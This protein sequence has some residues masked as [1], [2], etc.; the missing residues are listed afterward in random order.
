MA[1]TAEEQAILTQLAYRDIRVPDEA[2][3][4][5]YDILIQNKSYLEK[6][7]GENYAPALESLLEKT[8]T[9]DYTVIHSV[10]DDH[11][12]GFVAFAIKHPNNEV[13]VT[14]RGSEDLSQVMTNPDSQK[15]LDTDIQ[16]GTKK[17]TDQQQRME[18]FMEHLEKTGYD[19][20]Y[21]IGHSLGGNLAIHGAVSV[22]DPDK[23]KGV[24]TYNSPGFNDKYWTIYGMRMRQIEGKVVNYE[25]EYDY[26][27]SIFTKP[28]A[29]YYVDSLYDAGSPGFAH[30]SVCN[31]KIGEGGFKQVDG[32]GLRNAIPDFVTNILV[33]GAWGINIVAT[34]LYAK[35]T[36]GSLT[37][38]RDFSKSA[39]KTLT[40]AARET[41][42]E[43]WWQVNRWDCW[44][45][46]DQAFGGWVMEL[47]L[48]AGDVDT[49]YRKIIDINDASVADIEAI[50][51]K[52][53]EI[54][55]KYAGKLNNGTAQLTS[56]V[57]NKLR[58]ISDSITPNA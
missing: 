52:V 21:F 55:K 14:V 49:Y 41:E 40:N 23:V 13:T 47:Q 48:M 16:I 46:M 42:E 25:N 2:P 53:Y 28:G 9:Q 51:E 7:L 4:R 19:G 24:T 20:Y 30:H 36:G 33:D 11:D 29:T 1:F 10:D 37:G 34:Y 15:D 5:L 22:G 3:E 35:L 6:K 57:L 39:L 31:L 12:T 18:E 45:R 17:E 50:F 26:V 54:D 58:S 56:Q 43:E 44:Y 27:S 32:K 38:Y 8:R